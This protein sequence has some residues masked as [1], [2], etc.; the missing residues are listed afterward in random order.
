MGDVLNF[1]YCAQGQRSNTPRHGAF[2]HRPLALR[3]SDRFPPKGEATNLSVE[4]LL[5]PGVS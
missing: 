2:P 1:G 5:I 4:A 3:A